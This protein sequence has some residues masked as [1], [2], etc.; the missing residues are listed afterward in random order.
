MNILY[1]TSQST[2]SR[3]PP[4]GS[5]ASGKSELSICT[6]RHLW[7]KAEGVFC[8]TGRRLESCVYCP[9]CWM[10]GLQHELNSGPGNLL[11]VTCRHETLTDR[12]HLAG[13]VVSSSSSFTRNYNE[14]TTL[15]MNYRWFL[16]IP[17]VFVKLLNS[18]EVKP[19]LLQSESLEKEHLS[20]EK[21]L[22]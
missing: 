2:K 7:R 6:W 4:E 17:E 19:T 22:W 12:L 9:I 1:S 5:I 3:A 18:F 20:R 15:L 10:L 21:K 14:L 11:Q 8:L 13:A 16:L